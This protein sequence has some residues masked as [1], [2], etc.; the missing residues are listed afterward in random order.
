[1]RVFWVFFIISCKNV[2][3]TIALHVC[4]PKWQIDSDF[5]PLMLAPNFSYKYL[6]NI[7]SKLLFYSPKSARTTWEEVGLT[8]GVV[9]YLNKNNGDDKFLLVVWMPCV[10]PHSLSF[11]ILQ[12]EIFPAIYLFCLRQE[13]FYAARNGSQASQNRYGRKL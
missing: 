9:A 10:N 2:V 1:M 5:L 12:C 4:S 13:P 8:Y 11:Q 6:P 7:L 3:F